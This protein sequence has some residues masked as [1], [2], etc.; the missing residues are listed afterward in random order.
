MIHY[1][2]SCLTFP[3]SSQY[4]FLFYDHLCHTDN[5][6]TNDTSEIQRRILFLE[7]QKQN[8]KK[9]E[10]SVGGSKKEI[11]KREKGKEIKG[12]EERTI[13]IS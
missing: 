10:K 9:R 12:K 8:T 6:K 5:D 2:E 11:G 3:I 7:K 13:L 4:R 1:K